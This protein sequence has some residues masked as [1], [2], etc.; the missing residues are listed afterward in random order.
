MVNE[1]VNEQNA[2]VLNSKG[3]KRKPV[4][5]DVRP[6]Q[7]LLER[8]RQKQT[9]RKAEE[10]PIGPKPSK[11][12]CESE[13]RIA[14][15]QLKAYWS[16]FRLTPCNVDDV[17]NSNPNDPTGRVEATVPENSRGKGRKQMLE[18][19]RD[20][21]SEKSPSKEKENR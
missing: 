8:I 4:N 16:C 20:S 11:A 6:D 9:K 15:V 17:C 12:A 10:E 18:N 19:L 5:Q 2:T 3:R 13:E 1:N 21:I 7:A 14:Q